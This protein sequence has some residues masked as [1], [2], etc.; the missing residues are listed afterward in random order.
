M[1]SPSPSEYDP[2]TPSYDSLSNTEG[3]DRVTVLYQPFLQL[4]VPQGLLGLLKQTHY[5]QADLETLL[6]TTR[7]DIPEVKITILDGTLLTEEEC[8]ALYDATKE[9]W[10]QARG[11]WE[12]RYTREKKR[13]FDTL[14]YGCL[15]IR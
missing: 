3:S 4:E 10:G 12:E 14:M 6:D 2:S 11:C 15:R 5:S 9:M 8:N 13:R 7:Y 1:Y